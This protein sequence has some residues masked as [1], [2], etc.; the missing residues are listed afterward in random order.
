MTLHADIESSEEGFIGKTTVTIARDSKTT[1]AQGT[2]IQ[3]IVMMSLH[4]PNSGLKVRRVGDFD[5]APVGVAGP[6][7]IDDRSV[8]FSE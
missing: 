1:Y 6:L 4:S 2:V 5:L 7:F 3:R 8:T